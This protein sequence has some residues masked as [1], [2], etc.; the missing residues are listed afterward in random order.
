[1]YN[2]VGRDQ[3][4]SPALEPANLLPHCIISNIGP[5]VGATTPYHGSKYCITTGSQDYV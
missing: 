4:E 5:T 1:M 2:I 3:V